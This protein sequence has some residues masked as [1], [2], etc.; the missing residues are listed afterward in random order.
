MSTTFDFTPL[1]SS[2]IGV[3]RMA[4]LVETALRAEASASYPPYDIEM[5]GETAYR[6]SLAVAGFAPTDL[7]VIAE[8]NLLMIKG[9][10]AASEGQGARTFLHQGLAQRSFERR[11]ELADYVV[12][13]HAAH[14][15]GVLT[16]D[17]AREMPEALKP[18]QI[19]IGTGARQQALQLRPAKTRTAA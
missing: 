12:V 18:R 3:D 9:R 8:P 17:L 13:K 5:T 15:D 16:I 11:F 7:E 14:A 4:D 6:I 19:P 10:K 2:M 1:Y